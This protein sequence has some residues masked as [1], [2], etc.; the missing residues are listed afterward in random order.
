[1]WK[2]GNRHFLRAYFHIFH[3]STFSH[4]PQVN[5]NISLIIADDHEIF[6]DGL[7][8]MLS[9]QE[10]MSLVGQ[11]GNGRELIQLVTEKKPDIILTDIKMPYLDGIAATRMLLQKDPAMKIIALSMSEEEGLIVDMLEAGAKGYLLK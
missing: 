8:L 2:C 10:T 4:L 9:K 5:Y 6:R 1:M 3:I 11:A 7:A